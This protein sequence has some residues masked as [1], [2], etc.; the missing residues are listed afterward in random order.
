MVARWMSG[1]MARALLLAARRKVFPVR[2]L[3]EPE[4][5]WWKEQGL[6]IMYQIEHRPGIEWDRDYEEFNRSMMD[7]QGNLRFN[8]PFCRI[9][10]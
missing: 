7:D 10:E 2:H 1:E 4:A 6:G 3:P 9:A 5:P 8:G